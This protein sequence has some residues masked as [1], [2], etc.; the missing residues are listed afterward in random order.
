MASRGSFPSTM[1]ESA[2][3][4]I[5]LRAS[6]QPVATLGD[7]LKVHRELNSPL[8]TEHGGFSWVECR[9]GTQPPVLE[10]LDRRCAANRSPPGEAASGR[11]PW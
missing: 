2:S 10:L 1:R 7:A 11:A 6:R 3:L 5:S 8:L 4:A 9:T